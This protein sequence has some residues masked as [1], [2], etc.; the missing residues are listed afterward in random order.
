MTNRKF[1]VLILVDIIRWN[2]NRHF[3]S[4]KHNKNANIKLKV[5]S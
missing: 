3:K 4:Q 2:L 1:I 5:L